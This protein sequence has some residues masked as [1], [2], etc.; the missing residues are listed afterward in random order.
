M[1]LWTAAVFTLSIIANPFVAFSTNANAEPEYLPVEQSSLVYMETNIGQVIIQLTD[2]QSPKAAKQFSNL[3][4]EGFYHNQSFYRV[5]DGFVAQAGEM[6][7]EKG[8]S[9]KS[10]FRRPIPAEFTQLSNE[11]SAFQVVQ[12]PALLAPETGYWHN[13]PAG[14]DA[15][16]KERWL[17]HCPGAVAMARNN[18]PDSSSTEFY[19]V[20]GQAPRHL[21]RNM[22]VI[23]RVVHGMPIV[24]AMNR[25]ELAEGGI[26]NPKSEQVQIL[27]AT[28]GSSLPK[29]QQK[30]IRIANTKSDTFIKRINNAKH[31]PGPFLVYPGNGN[32]DVCYYQPS[33]K[34]G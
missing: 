21:D 19:I 1:K 31:N 20:I 26:V 11:Q 33:I 27:S 3:V 13:F 6:D 24:Q 29:A 8:V 14:Q 28:I 16:T 7:Y 2:L 5:I 9:K 23:G 18:D 32:V 25:G 4:S 10:D 22:S 12:S 34:I 15:S 17:L 30:N